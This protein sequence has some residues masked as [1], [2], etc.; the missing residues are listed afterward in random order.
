MEK[1][2]ADGSDDESEWVVVEIP[3][4]LEELGV[5]SADGSIQGECSRDGNGKEGELLKV[6]FFE[7][8]EYWTQA[9]PLGNGRLGAMVFGGVPGDLLQL[10]DDTLWSG[11]PKDWNNHHAKDVLPKVRELV[12]QGHYS[13]ATNLSLEMLGPYCQPYQPLGDLKLDFGEAHKSFDVDSYHRYLDIERATSSVTYTVEDITYTRE[14]FISQPHQVLV[15]K[16]SANKPKSVSLAVSLSSRLQEGSQVLNSNQILVKGHAPGDIVF[17]TVTGVGMAFAALLEVRTGDDNG[18]IEAVGDQTIRVAKADWVVV[19]LAAQTGFDGP[20]KHPNTSDKDPSTISLAAL[21]NVEKFSYEDLLEEH[22][23]DYQLLFQRVSLSLSTSKGHCKTIESKM[24]HGDL[25]VGQSSCRSGGERHG[26]AEKKLSTSDRVEIFKE[27]QDPR[28]VMLLFQFGRYLM[29]S[30]SRPGTFVSNL[31]G[32]WNKDLNPP[33]RCVPHININLPMNYWPAEVCN[34]SECHL[35]VFDLLATMAI[36]GH[37]TAQVNYGLDGWVGHHNVD[38]WGQTAPVAE[39]PVWALWPVGGAWLSLHL[40]EHYSFCLDKAFLKERAYPILRGCAEFLLTWLIEDEEGTLITN[41]STSPEHYFISPDTRQWA[42]VSYAT[43]MDLAIIREVFNSLI[44][45]AQILGD[46]DEEF[47]ARLK[48]ALGKLCPVKL[49]SD[50]CLLEWGDEF[51]DTEVNHR[52]MSH[53]FGLY[54]GHTLTL[55]TTPE[56]CEAATKSMIKRGE[57]GPGWSMAWKNALWAR[58]RNSEHAYSMVVR[59]F[60]LIGPTQTEESMDGG[61]LYGNLLNAHPPFQIDGN[62]GFTAAIAEMLLQSDATT[63]YL[64]P[65]LP[66]GKWPDGTVVGLRGRG[67]VTV[68]IMWAEG[69]LVEASLKFEVELK[70]STVRKVYYKGRTVEISDISIDHTYT[71]DRFLSQCVTNV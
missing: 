36:T 7:P 60:S 65:A 45:A 31:Q 22:L 16:I 1:S 30:S 46:I 64:L 35:P 55:Q 69:I 62:F 24:G 25:S 52:H 9:L 39:D 3:S 37:T 49:T 10:N 38:I 5:P 11:G 6:E 21:K 57:A 32:I 67:A 47:I 71:Y 17:D 29:L 20:F 54:P 43:A 23:K 28:M 18:I 8:A 34:L 59:M 40:W 56:L 2:H 33:W 4:A 15:V 70:P 42:S 63:V 66:E 51:I 41:P 44:E 14:Y 13:R 48:T 19:L 53:L 68:S 12:F 27:H 26:K 61:G 58:L 50:G